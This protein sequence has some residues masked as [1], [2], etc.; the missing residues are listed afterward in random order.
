M[1]PELDGVGDGW[2]HSYL[3]KEGNQMASPDNR[4]DAPT[5]SPTDWVAAHTK[6]YLESG[7]EEG[8]IWRNGAPT[9]LLTTTGRRSGRL[10][11]T[12][13]IYG[14]DGDNYLIVASK[15]GADEPPLWYLNLKANPEVA[16]QVGSEQVK[17]VARDAR[18]AEKRH[19]WATMARIW[20]DYDTYQTKTDREIPV[21]VLEPVR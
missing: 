1:P 13:L 10:R 12:P 15:G 8:H 6:E 9:L 14:R 18:P 21:I 19:L 20:P 17:A 3:A 4:P 2:S 7:G 5:D 16:L 11:R